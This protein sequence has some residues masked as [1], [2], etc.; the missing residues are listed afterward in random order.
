MTTIKLV[1]TMDD[2]ETIEFTYKDKPYLMVA[3]EGTKIDACA[4]FDKL[5][6]INAIV[7]REK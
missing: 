4:V 6:E 5:A 2:G 1:I 3:K 7:E